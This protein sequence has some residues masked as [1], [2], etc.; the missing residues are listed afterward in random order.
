MFLALVGVSGR[1]LKQSSRSDR[2][3]V[4]SGNSGK[5][6][7]TVCHPAHDDHDETKKKIE[8]F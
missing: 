2:F 7:A 1:S 6:R 8:D 3:S 4:A 5:L